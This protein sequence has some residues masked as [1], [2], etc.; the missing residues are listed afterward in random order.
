MENFQIIL[1]K[2]LIAYILSFN[3]FEIRKLLSKFFYEDAW[4]RKKS[5]L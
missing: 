1:P 5:K 2:Y 3:N 4:N